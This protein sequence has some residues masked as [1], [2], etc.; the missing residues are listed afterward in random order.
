M[1][2]GLSSFDLLTL[3]RPPKRGFASVGPVV[4]FGAVRAA[5]VH[6]CLVPPQADPEVSVGG[7]ELRDELLHQ[8]LL[9]RRLHTQQLP[10]VPPAGQVGVLEVQLPLEL[11]EVGQLVAGLPS[12][13]PA[14]AL[15]CTHTEK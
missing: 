10:A 15:T 8:L 1:K 12:P 4:L 14:H 11:G 3:S 6:L 5:A 7:A 2:D 13:R 9:W